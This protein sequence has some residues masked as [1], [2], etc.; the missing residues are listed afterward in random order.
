MLAGAKSLLWLWLSS[1]PAAELHG[2]I[3]PRQRIF[4]S[5]TPLV[6]LAS[7]RDRYGIIVDAGSTQTR[8]YIYQWEGPSNASFSAHV[9]PYNEIGTG[10]HAQYVKDGGIADMRPSEL[11]DFFSDMIKYAE[12]QLPKNKLSSVPI[13]IKATAGVRILSEAKRFAVVET[14]KK[15]LSDRSKSPFLF[16]KKLGVQILSGEFE[17]SFDWLSINYLAG[18]LRKDSVEKSVISIDMGGSSLELTFEPTETLMEGAF[19][20]RVNGTDVILYT[21]SYLKF[22]RNQALLRYQQDLL[23]MFPDSKVVSDPCFPKGYEEL[24][25][26]NGQEIL[27]KGSGN[28]ELC[29]KLTRKLLRKSKFCACEP[30]A[31][32]GVYQPNLPESRPIVA[33][34]SFAKIALALGC[35]GNSSLDCLEKMAYQSCQD[36]VVSVGIYKLGKIQKAKCFLA[37]YVTNVLRYGFRIDPFRPIW[38][39]DED[40]DGTSTGWTI[41]AMIYELELRSFNNG[42]CGV[43]DI[44]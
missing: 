18:T 16:D 12:S 36:A 27:F 1:V 13:F 4:N 30:C 15:Y 37:A 23:S 33:I 3:N 29:L 11:P 43:P 9:K 34:D 28:Y 40:S 5:L 26:R 14:L 6:P 32:N 31:M 19:P 22:G 17:G 10:K 35:Y 25:H 21:Q 39:T 24:S 38:F 42:D 8:L 44:L 2:S 41:G 7:S 20:L